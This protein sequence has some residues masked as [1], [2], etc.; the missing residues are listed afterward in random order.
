MK[1]GDPPVAVYT[2]ES[3]LK[4]P[5]RLAR[6]MGRDLLSSR[7]LAWRLMV[8]DIRAQYRQSLLGV[9]WAFVPP[10]VTALGLTLA[11]NSKVLSIGE[12]DLPYPA[13]VM[14]SMSLWQT[15]VEALQGPL[16]AITQAKSMLAKINFPREALILAQLGQVIFNFGIKFLFIAALFLWFRIPVGWTVILAPVALLHLIA[17]GT[18]FGL[19]LAPL[20]TLYQD[21]SRALPFMTSVWLFLTPV[22][23]PPPQA[24]LFSVIVKLNPV[25]PL[26]V[27]VRE[28]AAGSELSS[29]LGFWVAS[30]FAIA[31]VLAS[32][33]IYRVS[34]PFITERMSA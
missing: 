33:V 9:F 21:F 8:R 1:F 30:G 31:G 32:W 29:P 34:M 5:V 18:F 17:L 20:G 26:L 27:T 6:E 11:T 4:H 15:Y 2:P 25:T 13:Y 24:G 14:F 23:Y 10:V 22:I 19:F 3:K 16:Q 28:L 7:E 12:T